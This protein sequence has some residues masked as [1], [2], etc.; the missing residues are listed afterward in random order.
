[1]AGKRTLAVRLG[2]DRTRWLY[3]G[4]L[5]AA[6]VLLVPLAFSRPAA[7]LALVAAP[8]AVAAVGSVRRG[9]RGPE[10][11]PVLVATGRVQLLYGV[12]LAAGLALSA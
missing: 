6:F 11:I 2:D 3:T 5:V 9:A 7:L 4:L 10:L 8:S 1:M 12:F